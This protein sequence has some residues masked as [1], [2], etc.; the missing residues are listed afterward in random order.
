MPDRSTTRFQEDLVKKRKYLA[1]IASMSPEQKRKLRSQRDV[2]Y[3]NKPPKKATEDEAAAEEKE[4]CYDHLIGRCRSETE[5]GRW[6]QLRPPRFFGVCKFYLTGCCAN[7]ESCE[8]M[9]EDFPCR[10]YYLDLPH[11]NSV[12]ANNCRFRHGGPLPKR[13]YHYF[14]KQ[15]AIWAK[16]ITKEKMHEFDSTLK[17]YI[18]KFETKQ[19]KLEQEEEEKQVDQINESPTE[20]TNDNKFSMESILSSKQIKI[21]ADN[22]ITTVAQINQ[23]PIDDLIDF[24]LTIDQIYTITT[25]TCI[26]SSL[27]QKAVIDVDKNANDDFPISDTVLSSSNNVSDSSTDVASADIQ[28]NDDFGI[29]EVPLFGFA[30]IELKEAE[31]FLHTKRQILQIDQGSTNEAT[32]STAESETENES[33]ANICETEVV[34]ENHNDNSNG[35]DDSDNEFNLVINEDI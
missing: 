25:N 21:L 3:S 9:H 1:T 4:F 8:Y 20:T 14:K 6:H 13:L 12:D 2:R 35:S 19:L 5:C 22:H 24:G 7:G 29:D 26:E 16:E 18:D 30:Q 31:Q 28:S 23:V 34:N 27:P 15:I 32:T 17:F 10:F 33:E 11:P